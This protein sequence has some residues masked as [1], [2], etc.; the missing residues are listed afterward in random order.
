MKGFLPPMT[1]KYT[2]APALTP[3]QA[4]LF[5][6]ENTATANVLQKIMTPT[7]ALQYIDKQANKG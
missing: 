4:Q 7:Q 2:Q 6:A 3:T 5:D 1:S